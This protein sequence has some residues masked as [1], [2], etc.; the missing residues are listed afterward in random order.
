MRS[1][2]FVTT[3]KFNTLAILS[4]VLSFFVAVAAI[5]L[6]HIALSQIKRTHERGWGLAFAGLII[7]YVALFAGAVLL[8]VL[9][10][11]LAKAGY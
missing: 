9:F 11:P 6:G 3:E 10:F 4:F 7:G 5:A 1:A 2:D 8:T